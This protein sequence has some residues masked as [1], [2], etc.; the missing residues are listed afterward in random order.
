MVRSVAGDEADQGRNEHQRD[1]GSSVVDPF[2]DFREALDR[3]ADGLEPNRRPPSPHACLR[4]VQGRTQ[5][6]RVQVFSDFVNQILVYVIPSRRSS[7]NGSLVYFLHMKYENPE[8]DGGAEEE[9]GQETAKS[10]SA[11]ERV[12][13][14]E[15]IAR[16][17]EVYQGMTAFLR[18]AVNVGIT[19]A[20]FGSGVGDVFSWGAD[21]AK[22][23]GRKLNISLLDTTPDVSLLAAVITEP[24]EV[25]TGGLA[26]THAFESMLQARA[27]WPRMKVA[28]EKLKA[29]W[30]GRDKV[31]HTPEVA[32]ALQTFAK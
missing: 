30:H 26:S 32:A 5:H 2:T 28:Y 6:E 17:P 19:G 4:C 11:I 21:A 23:V 13:R 24:A 12:R 25:F 29:I 8:V 9:T 22:G 15:K 27:D 18:T 1:A 14:L 20:D 16:D 10:V 31:V 7:F 3:I